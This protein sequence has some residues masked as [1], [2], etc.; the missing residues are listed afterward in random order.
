LRTNGENVTTYAINRK[1]LDFFSDEQL[2]ENLSLIKCGVED[3]GSEITIEVTSDRPDL[4]SVQ[5][6]ERA[7]K[8]FL[9]IEPGLPSLSTETLKKSG[10]KVFKDSEISMIRPYIVSAVVKK[11]ISEDDLIDLMGVQERLHQTH[12]RKRKKISIGIHDAS[13]LKPPFYYKAVDPE[14]VSF[15]PLNEENE[16]N[17]KEILEKTQK[18]REYAFI[19]KSFDKYPLL[20]DSNDNV[21]SFPPII[22]GTLTALKSG[23]SNLFI[24]ITGTDFEACN[25]TLNIICQ[26]FKDQG[27]EVET[28]EIVGKEKTETP[29]TTPETMLLDL[30]QANKTLG[31]NLNEKE[32][33]KILRKQRL[34]AEN[35]NSE[36]Q[37]K[38]PR[39]R[40]DF[41]HS[42]DLI[43]EIAIGYSIN[44]FQPEMPSLFTKGG[45]S[46]QTILTE[47]TR[48]VMSASGFI[49]IANHV[50]TNEALMN[51]C[52]V[53]NFIRIQ[54]PVS[55]DYSTMRSELFPLLIETASKNTHHSYPQKLFE[56][57]EVVV[58][59]KQILTNLNVSALILSSKASLSEIASYFS[60]L[61]KSLKVEFSFEKSGNSKF[62]ENRG[63]SIKVNG[64]ER[65]SVGEVNPEI[66]VDFGIDVPASAFEFNLSNLHVIKV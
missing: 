10:V 62:L 2:K 40:T 26:D 43:E 37:C 28:V 49:E 39:Y 53:K 20:V 60:I 11:K 21:M 22:N 33:V 8:G 9:G 54:N 1:K 13:K 32:A 30:E 6:V 45:L 56:V 63:L 57:G 29:Q 25:S 65:G 36:I 24:D 7:L 16:M 31:I 18:G 59:E 19:V 44:K 50:L 3:F 46:D 66:L 17:L 14:S 27:A 38:I 23:S 55:S 12:G 15:T 47:K 64:V 35:I 58:P 34:G 52:F 48:N 42:A 4:L 51:K 41:I 61:S 5:G